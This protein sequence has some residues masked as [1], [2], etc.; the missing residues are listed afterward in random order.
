MGK[1]AAC[2]DHRYRV[3]PQLAD[4]A[5][6]SVVLNDLEDEIEIVEGDIRDVASRFDHSKVDVVVCN[7]PYRPVGRGPS[8]IRLCWA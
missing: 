7:P 4:M 8:R 2:S 1:V 6:R 5:R 3:Q